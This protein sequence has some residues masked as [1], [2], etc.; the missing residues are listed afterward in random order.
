VEVDQLLNVNLSACLFHFVSCVKILHIT[1]LVE[2]IKSVI[3]MGKL[4]TCKEND[5]VLILVI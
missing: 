1:F 4:K 3:K 2:V 5:I